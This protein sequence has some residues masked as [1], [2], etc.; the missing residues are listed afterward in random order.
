MSSNQ[1]PGSRNRLLELN[2][3]QT[4]IHRIDGNT[5][6][7]RIIIEQLQPP[8]FNNS[9][10]T[11]DIL[12]KLG[13]HDTVP[14]KLRTST[15]QRKFTHSVK[16]ENSDGTYT[17]TE[18][19]TRDPDFGFNDVKSKFAGYRGSEDFQKRSFHLHYDL[20][21]GMFEQFT[22][23]FDHVIN[24]EAPVIFKGTLE[25]NVVIN[26][27]RLN[28]KNHQEL[29]NELVDRFR[30]FFRNIFFIPLVSKSS[31]NLKFACRDTLAIDSHYQ[32][33]NVIEKYVIDIEIQIGR[34]HIE[35][36]TVLQ[37]M[38]TLLKRW[39]QMQDLKLPFIFNRRIR[40]RFK[41]LAEKSATLKYVQSVG[42]APCMQNRL[43]S[44][45]LHSSLE[46]EVDDDD[47]YIGNLGL[48]PAL[49]GIRMP[50]YDHAAYQTDDDFLEEIDRDYEV[51]A[52]RIQRVLER[53]VGSALFGLRG[54]IPPYDWT[55]NT[56]L[57]DDNQQANEG[58][59]RMTLR[60]PPYQ[61]PPGRENDHLFEE[62]EEEDEE[63]Y[64]MYLES[65]NDA[66][67]SD[68]SSEPDTDLDFGKFRI[69]E[70]EGVQYLSTRGSG[71]TYHSM[72][73]VVDRL[74]A[75]V[76]STCNGGV[77]YSNDLSLLHQEVNNYA[78]NNLDTKKK[79]GDWIKK[80]RNRFVL[81]L[82]QN[83]ER[84]EDEEEEGEEEAE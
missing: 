31:E 42:D 36:S 1:Q 15:E 79:Y 62:K 56:Q 39:L 37:V 74:R 51:H 65:D 16:L 40:Q 41:G 47:Y 77:Y 71:E 58:N 84:R 29:Y 80:L 28:M 75:H 60:V 24:F 53:P 11:T 19:G 76:L 26:N 7:E 57:R 64:P 46:E 25:L 73:D 63:D 23:F 22:L 59:R 8:R 66:D 81:V 44:R 68:T 30:I 61:D 70:H 27:S 17:R 78:I 83:M 21:D 33:E 18:E 72:I 12:Y 3:D 9:R 4:Q 13:L 54:H 48:M 10:M 20:R 35:V 49:R 5:F 69:H 67:A 45:G 50:R 14:I 43:I 2:R 34:S 52:P 82:G 6:P 38:D 55:N 32:V